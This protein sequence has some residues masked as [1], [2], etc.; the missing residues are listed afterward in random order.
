MLL[1]LHLWDDNNGVT[2]FLVRVGQQ[3]QPEGCAVNAGTQYGLNKRSQY[4]KAM[5]ALIRSSLYFYMHV[6]TQLGTT[7]RLPCYV[8]TATKVLG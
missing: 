4:K 6:I 8:K 1:C 7:K 5:L 3:G 2:T